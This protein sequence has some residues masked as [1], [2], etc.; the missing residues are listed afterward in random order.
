M[1]PTPLV[2]T[3][4]TCRLSS[5]RPMFN[6][7]AAAGICDGFDMTGIDGFGYDSAALILSEL[8]PDLSAFPAERHFVSY[9]GTAP[10]LGKS[11]GKNVSARRNHKNTS[12]VGLTLRMSAS[13]L[14]RSESALCARI[15]CVRSRTCFR[16]AIKDAAR[17][18]GKR[19]YRG[20]E[21]GQACVDEG[22][23]AYMSRTRKRT[24]KSMKKITKLG[25][26]VEELGIYAVAV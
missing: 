1:L 11:A 10:S 7:R 25:I 2:R 21:Y 23:Q 20:I 16:T 8:G 3:A 22:E 24:I 19:I 5:A 12:S 17:E 18:M 15:R 4:P 6:G 26:S 9:I 13:S 14:F